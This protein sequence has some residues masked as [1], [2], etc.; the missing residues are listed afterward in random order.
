MGIIDLSPNAL[1]VVFCLR[2]KD[3]KDNVDDTVM[4]S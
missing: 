2:G 4:I 1:I 3:T